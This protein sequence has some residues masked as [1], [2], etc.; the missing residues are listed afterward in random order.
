MGNERFSWEK[1]PGYPTNILVGD[2]RNSIRPL[3][4][5][6][7]ERRI[8]RE[9]I[10]NERA[11]FDILKREMLED[12]EVTLVTVG[13]LGGNVPLDFELCLRMRQDIIKKV[14]VEKQ[15]VKF[16]TFKDNCSTFLSLPM[17][18]KKAGLL[19]VKIIHDAY[20]RNG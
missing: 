18:I 10:W 3:G 5:N 19:K 17:S 8:S 15:E 9:K 11:N 1:E 16:E 12:P 13:Y 20:R 14:L 6:P 4:R 2:F 7:G